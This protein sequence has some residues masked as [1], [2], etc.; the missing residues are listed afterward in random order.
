MDAAG[1]SDSIS[2]DL[3]IEIKVYSARVRWYVQVIK[4]QVHG[5]VS[6]R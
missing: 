4:L 1:F 2:C 5:A 6:C 3:E